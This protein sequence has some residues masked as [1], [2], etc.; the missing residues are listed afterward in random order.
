MSRYDV[1]EMPTLLGKFTTG[2]TVRIDI[3]ELSGNTKIVNAVLCTELGTSG[4]FVY[5]PTIVATVYKKYAWIMTNGSIF[6]LDTFELGGYPTVLLS[7][8]PEIGSGSTA[9][10]YTI[11]DSGTG[12]P[13]ADV[14][15]WISTDLLGINVIASGVTDQSGVCEFML[16]AGTIYVWSSKSG[17]NFSNP[18]QETVT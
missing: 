8:V 12:V 4:L 17:Y 16:D 7:R 14:D 15:V 6:A 18:D 1:S 9:W 3:Y 10:S 13:I 2:D 5:T 11:T